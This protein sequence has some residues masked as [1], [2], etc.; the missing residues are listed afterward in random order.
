MSASSQTAAQL[1]Q[2]LD[3]GPDRTD[4]HGPGAAQMEAAQEPEWAVVM[5]SA[6][7]EDLLVKVRDF[8]R[9][10]RTGLGPDRRRAA[11]GSHA[12]RHVSLNFR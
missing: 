1:D 2:D 3:G 4:S 10:A 6:V 5:G 12:S 11:L 7:T 8:A 9:Y